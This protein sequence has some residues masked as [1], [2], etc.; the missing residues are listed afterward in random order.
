MEAQFRIKITSKELDEI[1]LKH[2]IVEGIIT[3]RETPFFRETTRVGSKL[4]VE[5]G[6]PVTHHPGEEAVL[7]EVIT[8]E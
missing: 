6:L 5:F 8:T 4:F 2:L 7:E 3:E 1:L